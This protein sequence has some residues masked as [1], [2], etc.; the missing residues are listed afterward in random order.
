MHDIYAAREDLMERK[1]FYL[2][3]WSAGM[4]LL[5]KKVRWPFKEKDPLIWSFTNVRQTKEG[6]KCQDTQSLCIIKDYYLSLGIYGLH[7]KLLR[8]TLLK[9]H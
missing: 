5:L 2:L 4:Q 6:M 8:V 3:R 1:D 7:A 9:D